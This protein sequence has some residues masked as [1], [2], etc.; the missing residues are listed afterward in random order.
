MGTVNKAALELATNYVLDTLHLVDTALLTSPSET[1]QGLTEEEASKVPATPREGF[2]DRKFNQSE[3]S[4]LYD[5]RAKAKAEYGE[6]SDEYTLWNDALNALS[7]IRGYNLMDTELTRE[8]VQKLL[9][10]PVS[11]MT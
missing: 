10:E 1:T 3:L 11:E 4:A 6:K 2:N 7:V 9:S 8:A 5:L